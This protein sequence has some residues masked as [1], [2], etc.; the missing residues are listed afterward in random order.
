[1][2]SITKGAALIIVD[3][4]ND[5]CSGGSLEV[6]EAGTIIPVI[7]RLMPCFKIVVATQDWHPINHCSFKDW[8]VHCIAGTKGAELHPGLD[9]IGIS[10]YIKKGTSLDKDAYS[11]F[12]DTELFEYLKKNKVEK[13]FICGLAT[14][15]CVNA[16]ALDAIKND[17]QVYVFK[18]AI[19]GVN[20]DTTKAAYEEMKK[21]GVIFI[22]SDAI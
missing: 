4:Q 19:K 16:T 11:G 2:S 18:D 20:A 21:K 10:R 17:F 9:K 3:L 5:F 12:Q 7:N 15:V 1:M 6:D 13:I 14:D 8:P 22:Y